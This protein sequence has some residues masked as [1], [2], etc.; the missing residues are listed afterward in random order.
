MVIHH[1][2][3]R[4]HAVESSGQSLEQRND[5]K[6]RVIGYN[7]DGDVNPCPSSYR[8]AHTAPGSMAATKGVR[9][10]SNPH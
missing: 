1:D 9:T 2:D 7:N 8:L 5:L 4:V 6:S 10:Q 3:I